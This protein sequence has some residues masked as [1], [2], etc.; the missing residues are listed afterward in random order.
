MENETG[1][2]EFTWSEG[3]RKGYVM[4]ASPV[5]VDQNAELFRARNF[6]GVFL[7]LGYCEGQV[8]CISMVILANFSKDPCGKI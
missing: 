4:F 6:T 8:N 3:G 1:V 5:S 2:E 7:T